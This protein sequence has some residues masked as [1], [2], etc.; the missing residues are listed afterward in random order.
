MNLGAL[1]PIKLKNRASKVPAIQ[2]TKKPN[3]KKTTNPNPTEEAVIEPVIAEPPV[4]AKPV[5][6]AKPEYKSI[7]NGAYDYPES[8]IWL[9]GFPRYDALYNDTKRIIFF[10]C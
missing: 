8:V 2:L 3:N 9:T 1:K 4:A 6:S 10:I 5:V 7:V